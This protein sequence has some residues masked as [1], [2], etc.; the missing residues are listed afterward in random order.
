METNRRVM[1]DS[2]DVGRM[3][4]VASGLFSILHDYRSGITRS[5]NRPYHTNLVG[6]W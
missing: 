2:A 6:Y 3:D 1:H 4:G 5:S